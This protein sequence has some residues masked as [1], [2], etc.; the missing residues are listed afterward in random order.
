MTE[1]RETRMQQGVKLYTSYCCGENVDVKGDIFKFKNEGR[2]VGLVKILEPMSPNLNYYE[3]KIVS[4]GI[5]CAIGVGVGEK[6]YSLDR[7]PGWNRNG[8]GYHADDGKMFYQ[9]GHGQG[10]GPT[11]TEGDRMGCGVDFDTD[12]GQGYVSIFFTKN[13]KQIGE[14]VRMRLPTSGLYPIIRLHNRGE[15]VRYLG[16]WKRTPD[17]VQKPT[18]FYR[19]V[20][21]KKGEDQRVASAS[22]SRNGERERG[23]KLHTQG[24]HCCGENATV[25]GDICTFRNVDGRVG[26]VKILEPM[27]PKL[28]YYECEIVCRGSDCIVGVGVGEKQYPLDRQPGWNRNGIG[29]HADDGKMFYQNGHG[30]AFGPTCTEGDR[31]GCG[32]DFD[33]DCGQGNVSIFF[34]KN[35]KQIGELVR[36][37]LPTSGLYPI[38]GLH[39]RG[40]KVRY[41]GHWKRTPDGVQKPTEDYRSVVNKKGENQRVASASSSRNGERER[42]IKL[43]TQGRHCCGENATVDGDICT[44]RNVD[45]RVGVVKLLEPMSLELNYYECEIVC[46]GSKC[47]IGVGVGEKGYPLD[48]QPGWNGNGIGY[49]ADDGNMFYQNGHGQAFGPTCTEGDRMGCGVDFDTDCGQGCVSI[50]FTKNGKQIGELVRMRLP[51]SGLYPI[52]GLHSRGEKVRYLGHWKRTPD[53][54]QKPTE[55]YRSVVNKKGKDQR[56]ASASSSRKGARERGIKLHTQ[57]RHCCGENATVDDPGDIFTFRNVDGRVGVVKILEPMSPELNYYECEIVCRGSDCIIGVGVGE[58]EY[59]LDRQPGWNRN[60]IGYHA[61]DGKMFYQNGHGQAFGPTCTEGDRMGCGVDFDTD[62]GQGNV[63]IFFTKNGKQI[64]KLVRMRLPTNG[65]YPIIGLHSRGEKVRYLGHWKRTPDEVQKPTMQ[66]LSVVN[67]KEKDTRAVCCVLQKGETAEQGIKL[68]TQGRLSCGKNAAVDGDIFKFKVSTGLVKIL[69]PMTPHLNYFECEIV[70]QGTQCAVGVGVGEQ[71]YPLDR[72][73]GWKRNGIGYHADDG[74]MFYQ[75]GHGQAF[76]PTCTEGDRMGCGVDFDTDC[77][78]DCVSVFFTKNGEQIG[79]LVRMRLPTNGLYPI[80]GLHNK[81]EKVRY[82]GHWKRAPVRIQRPIRH[83]SLV[84]KSPRA[85]GAS[86]SKRGEAIEQGIKL[87]TQGRL[88]CGRNAAV[89]GDIFKFKVSTGL[90]KILVP[91]TTH[92]NYFEY[93]IVSQGT[94][95]AIGVGVGEREYPLDHMPGWKRNGIGYHA[96]DGKIFYQSGKGE[97]FGPTCTEGDRMGCGVDFDTDSGL[98]NVSIFFTKNGEQVGELV[99]MRLPTYGLYPIIGL[100]SKGEKVRY[101]GHWKRTPDGIPKSIEHNKSLAFSSDVVNKEMKLHYS[102]DEKDYGLTCANLPTD[103]LSKQQCQN[104]FRLNKQVEQLRGEESQA[105][106]NFEHR[107]NSVQHQLEEALQHLDQKK[108]EAAQQSEDAAQMREE[109]T[110][111]E[112]TLQLQ[113][114]L[115]QQRLDTT[116]AELQQLH[117]SMHARSQS[118]IEACRVPRREVQILHEMDRG[119][120]G[121]VAQGRFQGQLVAVKWPHPAILNEHTTE[122]FQREVQIMA[123]VRHPNLLRFIASVFDDKV[124]QL[125]PLIVTELLDMNLRTAYQKGKLLSSGKIQIFQDIAYALHYLHGYQQPIIHRDVSAPN[126][127]LEK[128]PNEMWRA[129]I[130]DFGSANLASLAQTMGEGTI[131]YAA[132]ETIPQVYDPDTLALPQ[133]AKI[134]VYSY[135]VLMCEITTCRFPI[136]AQYRN[137]LLQVLSQSPSIHQLIIQCTKRNPEERP[138]MAQILDKLNKHPLPRLQ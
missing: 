52:I 118:K 76:G 11:C 12:C 73:P 115:L 20:V 136:S 50:F 39:S 109:A 123:Q 1:L 60:G 78:Q 113:L 18:E 41:L 38:I 37:R 97:V 133:T 106:D 103:Q 61:D 25:D 23:I 72:M 99:R 19:S 107:L 104:C 27:S 67:K 135:G 87:H 129:K 16:H 117:F 96:D 54:V 8:I 22:S 71:E 30:Q 75:N 130:S 98:G 57:G 116:T 2:S 100:H 69:L 43:H 33:T 85:I 81:G 121:T 10:F 4:Q 86:L 51:T 80:I 88:S 68:H 15:K 95:C 17:G 124:P 32:V 132:P 7:M 102:F 40:E 105:R 66:H 125:P 134:D 34:T 92:L 74:K 90:V 31:M 48:R 53:G 28:N 111:R 137:M 63:S 42:A 49:H 59:P 114:Q 122:R 120:W 77:G 13:G 70:S 14:L 46:R 126:V 93:E 101:L 110:M 82:L 127:L 58:K 64:G 35:G 79:E 26:V 131:I 45:G 5:E 91:M 84:K 21:N 138:T 24:R 108:E 29:Y 65:L 56:V 6:E 55:V 112:Q 89:D 83:H 36:M 3:C 94:Q 119:A 9:N 62:C 47:T 128:L 44:Y